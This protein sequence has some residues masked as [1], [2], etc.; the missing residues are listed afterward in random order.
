MG[1][2]IEPPIYLN[3]L[4]RD[5]QLAGGR[6]VVREFPDL[7]SVLALPEPVVVNCSGLGA[8]SLFGDESVSP[9]PGQLIVCLPQPEID[10]SGPVSMLSRKDGLVFGAG[11][12]GNGPWS[13]EPNEAVVRETMA[14]VVEFFHAMK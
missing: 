5:F 4:T 3:A 9:G 1:L 7:R 8:R 11:N 6:I 14:R 10:Y 2:L 12:P 13:L